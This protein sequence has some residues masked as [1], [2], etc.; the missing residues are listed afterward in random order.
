MGPTHERTF[1]LQDL[2]PLL[3]A[4]MAPHDE[5]HT[6]QIDRFGDDLIRY[7]IDEKGV[8]LTFIEDLSSQ[9]KEL[10]GYAS[11]E[12]EKQ[13]L[14]KSGRRVWGLRG[15]KPLLPLPFT[16]PQLQEFNQRSGGLC[17][18]QVI[19]PTPVETLKAVSRLKAQSLGAAELARALL[20]PPSLPM[21]IMSILRNDAADSPADKAEVATEVRTREKAPARYA[22]LLLEILDK[23]GVDATKVTRERGGA[24]P[25]KIKAEVRTMALSPRYKAQGFTATTFRAAWERLPKVD[26]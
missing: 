22:R 13:R 16:L 12:I 19:Y 24:K 6:Y 21:N 8:W 14:L 26:C 10:T 1:D 25:N 18:E 2:I 11:T 4:E 23:L 3:G 7:L 17:T 9:I 15:E 5:E 20:W